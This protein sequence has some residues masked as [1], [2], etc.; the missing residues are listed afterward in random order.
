MTKVWFVT[1]YNIAGGKDENILSDNSCICVFIN[2]LL[3][4]DKCLITQYKSWNYVLR[5]VLSNFKSI[6]KLLKSLV[7]DLCMFI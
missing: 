3:T 7:N 6:N 4:P 1:H 5:Y 2:V